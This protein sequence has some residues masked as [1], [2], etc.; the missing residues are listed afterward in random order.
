MHIGFSFV[1][2]GVALEMFSRHAAQLCVHAEQMGYES[3]WISE[4][5]IKPTK[6]PHSHP[7]SPGGKSTAAPETELYDPWVALATVAA[8]TKRLKL[9]TNV[10]VLPLRNPFATA[11]AV[12]TLDVLS[13][14][15][16][17]MGTGVGWLEPEFDIVG[18]NFHTRGARTDEII[19]IIRRLWIDEN[20]EFHGKFYDF[21]S[22]RFEPKPIQ[23]PTPPL[24]GSGSAKAALQRAARLCDGWIAD[25]ATA[26]D[27]DLLERAV[28]EIRRLREECG[29]AHL[30][31]Q[32]QTVIDFKADQQTRQRLANI[33]VTRAVIW[34]LRPVP[35]GADGLAQDVADLE[36]AARLWL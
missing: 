22:C 36:S 34:P 25:P 31:Y 19:E 30:P 7:H 29:R 17:I 3:C 24:L 12:S 23:K 1:R 32:I 27:L 4:H 20:V 35:P 33:G 13:G 11:R 9:G 2:Q 28:N 8:L 26:G 10:F 21:Q 18:E 14:G 15:R 16:V 5:L 6:L